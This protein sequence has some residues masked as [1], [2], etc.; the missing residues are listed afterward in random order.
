MI[1]EEEKNEVNKPCATAVVWIIIV[2]RLPIASFHYYV[3]LFLEQCAF[4][5]G[6]CLSIFT[7]LWNEMKYLCAH[8]AVCLLV[9]V[10]GNMCE[11]QTDT[12]WLDDS[13]GGD[14]SSSGEKNRRHTSKI[15]QNKITNQLNLNW[16]FHFVHGQRA[17][18]RYT[19]K[20]IVIN[21]KL[22]FFPVYIVIA[23]GVIVVIA[24]Q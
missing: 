16:E 12:H 13:D 19:Y 22:N 14:G 24:T 5:V 17:P 6:F 21:A 7:S 3:L 2:L 4:V 8:R 1:E 11:K 18:M 9:N 23:V 20:G 15:K 10:C